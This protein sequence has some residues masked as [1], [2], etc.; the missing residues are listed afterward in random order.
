MTKFVRYL[1]NVVA[2]YNY[3]VMFELKL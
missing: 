3:R 2:F 1:H